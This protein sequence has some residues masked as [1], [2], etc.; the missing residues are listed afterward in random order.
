[1]IPGPLSDQIRGELERFVRNPPEKPEGMALIAQESGVLPALF[2]WTAFGG[3]RVDGSVVW[4]EYDAPYR[5]RLAEPA[6][7]RNLI[8]HRLVQ[9]YSSLATLAPQ[10]PPD[11][12]ECPPCQGTGILR[13]AGVAQ[14]EFNCVCGGLGWL[15]P[16][17]VL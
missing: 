8:L 11:A 6:Y 10:R 4:V 12:I 9:R 15:P 14:P 13:I 16:G 3:I 5:V 7:V 1:M 17:T 2:D